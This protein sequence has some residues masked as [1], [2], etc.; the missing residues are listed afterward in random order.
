[1]SSERAA[2]G[3]I[4]EVLGCKWTFHVIRHLSERDARFNE[5]KRAIDGIPAST[6]S[7][8]LDSLQEEGV[9]ERRVEDSSPPAVEYALTTKGEELAAIVEDI[10]D[11]ESRYE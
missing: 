5:I 8:R 2:W 7:T 4:W 11:L 9:V 1:M 10:E 3:G 6:L